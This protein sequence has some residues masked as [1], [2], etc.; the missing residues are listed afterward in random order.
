M[1]SFLS[2][3]GHFQFSSSDRRSL[4]LFQKEEEGMRRR[5]KRREK[6]ENRRT[7]QLWG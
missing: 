5:R 3:R 2:N 6:K 7:V 4:H 1:V